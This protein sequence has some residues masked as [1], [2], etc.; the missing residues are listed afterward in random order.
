VNENGEVVQNGEVKGTLRIVDFDKP[1]KMLRFGESRFKPELPD[2]QER[3]SAGF[4]VKEGYLEGSNVNAIR[5]MVQMISTYRN[6]EA[7]Q[8]AVQAQDQTLEK[9]VNT[10]GRVG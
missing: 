2:A 10:V 8:K 4:V 9:A 1:Y 6:F 7:D 3:P 5:N